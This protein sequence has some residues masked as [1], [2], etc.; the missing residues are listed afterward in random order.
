MSI[1][2]PAMKIDELYGREAT[3][4]PFASVSEYRS[5]NL[6]SATSKAAKSTTDIK[7]TITNI[8]PLRPVRLPIDRP[9][10]TPR[11]PASAGVHGF[12]GR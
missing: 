5:R 12:G 1:P 8:L 9:V 6:R 10:L 11:M 2:S 4:T 7:P 3:Q